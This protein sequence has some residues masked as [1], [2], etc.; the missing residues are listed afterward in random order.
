MRD[1]ND[2]RM[3]EAHRAAIGDAI[4]ALIGRIMQAFEVLHRIE[5]SAPWRNGRC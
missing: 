3:L 5:W 1:E 4:D 2:M